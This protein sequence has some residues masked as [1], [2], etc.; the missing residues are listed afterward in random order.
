MNKLIFRKLSSDIFTFFFVSSFSVA[1]IV[2]VIQAVNFLDIV[3]EDGYG[4]KIYF[5]YTILNLP[6]I[7]SRILMIIFFISSF[8][9]IN[10]YIENNE[11]LVF[12]SN[13][14][15]KIL[16]INFI[17]KLSFIFV[18]LQLIL[19]V[20]VVPYT[21]DYNRI[22]VKNSNLD[23][24]P[25]LIS[26]K[27]F[28]NIFKNLTIFIDKYDQKGNL[29]N[30]YI[31]EKIDEDKSKIVIAEKGKISKIDRGYKLNLLQGTM[32]NSN[33]ENIYKINFKETEYDLS[34]FSSKT[35]THQKI[36]QINSIKI[37]NCVFDYYL[38]GFLNSKYCAS[39]SIKSISEEFYKRFI[40]PFYILILSLISSMLIIVP[41][42][43]IYTKFQKLI[44]FN[45]GF[46][47]IILSQVSFKFIVQNNIINFLIIMFPL[48]LVIIF[49]AYL[50]Y[51]TK[52]KLNYL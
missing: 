37:F 39:R 20:Y 52:F 18:I 8:Y 24:L 22:M 31:N 29:T 47:I 42:K 17:I 15:K 49:Y 51:R 30:V 13:G 35:V 34:K 27:K 33:K 26:E 9:I 38:K 5:Y 3:S 41:K 2:W 28:L 36:Q 1:I 45:L 25:N 7:F 46:F 6:K 32:I 10:K 12:W 16:F 48:M 4:L 11:I 43:I 50:L 19:N 14:I 44:I 21:Q 40:M 23:F